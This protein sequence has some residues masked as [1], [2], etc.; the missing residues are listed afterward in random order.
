[1]PLTVD[2]GQALEFFSSAFPKPWPGV[3]H[4]DIIERW[5]DKDGK[6][7]TRVKLQKQILSFEHLEQ[8]F[9][10]IQALNLMQDQGYNFFFSNALFDGSGV[11]KKENVTAL[12]HLWAD[13]DHVTEE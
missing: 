5:I 10:E 9:S 3:L 6:K 4:I 2:T 11:R 13:V 1:M 12:T 7:K 8:F